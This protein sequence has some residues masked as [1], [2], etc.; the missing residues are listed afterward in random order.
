MH[1]PHSGNVRSGRVQSA[2]AFCLTQPRAALQA[3]CL[4]LS[5]TLSVERA[6]TRT[7]LWDMLHL[8]SGSI[9]RPGM[10]IGLEA[11][12]L[13]RREGRVREASDLYANSCSIRIGRVPN[14]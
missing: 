12:Q 3:T 14:G 9:Q 1:R 11:R 8:Q 5:C 10:H 7:F 2:V 6:G 4:K 13:G